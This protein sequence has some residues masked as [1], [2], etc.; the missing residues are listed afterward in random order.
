[1]PRNGWFSDIDSPIWFDRL[2]TGWNNSPVSASLDTRHR[3]LAG[4]AS[5]PST[6]QLGSFIRGA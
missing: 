4:I 3:P 1:M 5:I 2:G 6:E